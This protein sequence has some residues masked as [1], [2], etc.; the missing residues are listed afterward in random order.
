MAIVKVSS[1]YEQKIGD[2]VLASQMSLFA[3]TDGNRDKAIDLAGCQFN[4]VKY[5][6]DDPQKISE[7]F[8]VDGVVSMREKTVRMPVTTNVDFTLVFNNG[9][10]SPAELVS[11]RGCVDFVSRYACPSTRCDQVVLGVAEGV[12]VGPGRT[13]DKYVGF[14]SDGSVLDRKAS[15]NALRAYLQR[16]LGAIAPAE[17]EV[18]GLWASYVAPVSNCQTCNPA[19]RRVLVGGGGAAAVGRLTTNR[20]KTRSNLA[21]GAALGATDVVTSY[22]EEGQLALVSFSTEPNYYGTLTSA[23]GGIAYSL[24]GGLTWTKVS[25]ITASMFEIVRWGGNKWIAVGNLVTYVSTDGITWT[26]YTTPVSGQTI[27]HSAA[28]E[29]AT[30]TLIVAGHTG[31]TSKGFIVQNGLGRDMSSDA[32]FASSGVGERPTK[33]RVFRPGHIMIGQTYAGIRECFDY[34]NAPTAWVQTL[35]TPT[36]TSSH[37]R[38]LFMVN[39]FSYIAAAS[40]LYER[41]PHTD[42]DWREVTLPSGMS[43]TGDYTALNG[44]VSPDGELEFLFGLTSAGEIPTLALC[45]PTLNDLLS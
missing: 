39:H 9:R 23:T 14:G 8:M 20:F 36:G 43:V 42:W 26:P 40:K 6:D 16:G 1:Q 38:G 37:T 34:A 15:G 11:N 31:V 45:Q 29:P 12:K 24:N 22:V 18:N 7:S 44:I 5:N 10:F 33:V 41:T 4:E 32:M 30:Q 17:A 28:Y 25:G 35:M 2:Q 27:W 21:F 3:V 13:L 19:T